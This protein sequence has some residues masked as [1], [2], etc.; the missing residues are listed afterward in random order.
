MNR[1]TPFLVASILAFAAY[2]TEWIRPVDVARNR[3]FVLSRVFVC[4][5]EVVRAELKASAAGIGVWRING[6]RVGDAYYEPVAS[7]YERKVFC[8]TY[9]IASM[10]GATNTVEVEVGGG[11]WEQNLAWACERRQSLLGVGYGS[12]A[13]WGEIAVEC[14]DG[15]RLL[16]E[17]DATWTARDGR[18][19]WNNIYGGEVFDARPATGA[20]RPVH[21]V[22]GL[23]ARPVECP[24]A[25]CRRMK[26][27]RGS[28]SCLLGPSGDFWICDFGTNLA[29]TVSF[30]LPPLVPGSRLKV[31]LA[32]TLTAEGFLDPR[33]GGSWATHHAPEYVYIAPEVP[34]PAKWTPEFSYTSFRFAEIS[35]FEPYPDKDW[36]AR[37]PAGLV[38]AVMIATDAKRTGFVKCGHGPTQH[39][40]DIADWT[41]LCNMHGFPEDCPGRE[42]GGWL[43][44][45]QVVCAYALQNFDLAALYAKFC[46][47]ISD[48][49]AVKGTIPFQVPTHRAFSWGAASP[50]WRAAAVVIPYELLM[51]CADGAA[52]SNNWESAEHAL[53]LFEKEAEGGLVRTGLGDWMPPCAKELKMPVAHS[54]SLC[55]NDCA[56]KTAE[57]AERLGLRTGDD[58]RAVARR[59]KERFISE[60][61]DRAAHTYG[62]DGT[63]AA[64]CCL[65]VFPE[66]DGANLVGAL[67]ARLRKNGHRMTTGI[68]S[69]PYLAKA[70]VRAG[71]ADDLVKCF[72]GDP[73]ASYAAVVR[74]GHTTMPEELRDQ[75]FVPR[76]ARGQRSLS[77]PMHCGWLRVLAEDVAGI[78]PLEPG[79]ARFEVAPCDGDAYRELSVVVPTPTGQIRFSRDGGGNVRLAVPEGTRCEYRP[80]GAALPPGEYSF[81]NMAKGE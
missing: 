61:Y 60:F 19:V 38:E 56:N 21:A 64:A 74:H 32:E 23:P 28:Y 27:F 10:L 44:D 45:A 79:Y 35:G 42:K 51:R 70:L 55:W 68:Y 7:Y 53:A 3:S 40:V 36:G 78:A 77:H 2:A 58:Y 57:M 22:E 11:W 33:S 50:L 16:L 76:K 63:D 31:R 65:G 46:G 13:A 54:S 47:D 59:V 81:G 9:D 25:P 6:K 62:H 75:L 67:V 12:P 73:S 48:G 24:V 66:G 4:T 52:A 41:I 8:R 14:A 20:P 39:I 37:P 49:I 43:G 80:T 5:G 30:N 17:T 69:S 26:T 18:S 72:F 34:T 1:G 29:G 71:H 15:E